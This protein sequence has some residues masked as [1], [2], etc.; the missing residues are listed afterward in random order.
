M[1]FKENLKHKNRF[2]DE[3]GFHDPIIK[4]D[5]RDKMAKAKVNKV[6][7]IED[8]KH[9]GII[10]SFDLRAVKG[11]KGDEFEYFEIF[12]TMPEYDDL[13]IKCSVPFSISVNTAL[14]KILEN[15]GAK[16]KDGADVDTEDFI[17]EGQKVQ[18]LTMKKTTDKGTFANIQPLSL[19]PE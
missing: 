1:I 16:L 18:F 9:Q 10:D 13:K 12:I 11:K 3:Y 19:R 6:I 14:G 15:F 7:D 4:K 5:G 17:K 8:G 2:L